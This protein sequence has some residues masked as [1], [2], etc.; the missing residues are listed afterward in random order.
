MSIAPKLY[1]LLKKTYRLL[2]SN[3]RDPAKRRLWQTILIGLLASMLSITV[4]YSFCIGLITS[5]GLLLIASRL[6]V[7]PFKS[8]ANVV[9]VLIN[10]LVSQKSNKSI[11]PLVNVKKN[12]QRP[13]ELNKKLI[14]AIIDDDYQNFVT[15]LNQGAN[16][17]AVMEQIF[18]LEN[19]SAL[20]LAVLYARADMLKELLRRGANIEATNSRGHTALYT[21]ALNGA[22]LEIIEILLNANAKINTLNNAR[23]T[24]LHGIAIKGIFQPSSTDVIN[25]LVNKGANVNAI[26]DENKTPLHYAVQCGKLELVKAFLEN[27]ARVDIKSMQGLPILMALDSGKTEMFKPLLK[28]GLPLEVKEALRTIAC[29]PRNSHHDK[30]IQL[31]NAH[32]QKLKS[33]LPKVQ[34]LTEICANTVYYKKLLCEDKM[35]LPLECLGFIE[36]API[37]HAQRQW[38]KSYQSIFP[39]YLESNIQICDQLVNRP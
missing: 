1:A 26:D 24:P 7:T 31:L 2:V 32:Y 18:D 13:E 29:T 17:N 38:M 36:S 11:S 3:L 37:R 23:R 12:A 39:E 21:A 19:I 9:S 5:V 20:S 30:L 28:A 8:V 34:S 27:G 6:R 15:L 4:G 25:Y 14:T 33:T 35:P 22:N 10:K 16:P